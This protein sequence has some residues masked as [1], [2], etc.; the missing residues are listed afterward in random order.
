MTTFFPKVEFA[1]IVDYPKTET[2]P[3]VPGG[4]IIDRLFPV[5]K[6]CMAAKFFRRKAAVIIAHRHYAEEFASA[7]GPMPEREGPT[8]STG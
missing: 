5:V 1:F 4:V 2:P 3:P 6:S 7:T 8:L